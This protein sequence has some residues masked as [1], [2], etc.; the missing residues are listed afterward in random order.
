MLKIVHIITRFING[1]A[2]ENTLETCNHQAAAGHDVTL[3]Y[4]DEWTERMLARLNAG[5]TKICVSNLK[6]PVS[7]LNDILA[8]YQIAQHLKRIEPDVIHTHTSKA[9]FIG[10]LA[11]IASR[12]SIVVHGVHILPFTA[13]NKTQFLTYLAL[14]KIAAPLTD[15]FIDVSEGMRELCLKHKLGIPEN[16]DVIASGMDI[17]RFRRAEP[18]HDIRRDQNANSDATPLTLT[19][20]AVLERRKCHHELMTAIAPILLANPAT[21]LVFAG[22]GPERSK[23]EAH[24]RVLGIAQQMQFIGFRD[25]A[26]NVIAASDICLFYSEREGLPRSIVQYALGGKP[27]LAMHLP[28]IERIVRDGQNGYVTDNAA[29]F[30]SRLDHLLHSPDTRSDFGLHSEKMDLSAWSAKFMADEIE[31]VYLR[32]LSRR[33]KFASRHQKK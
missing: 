18:A 2:D 14:E 31:K 17:D 10:R 33:I 26:A 20:V 11:S 6:R 22:E 15:H 3:I 1:G 25:D 23:L 7:P 28:G 5:I 16:H 19:Y 27:I 30:A 8:L 12:K 32:A 9:G 4:G 29:D 13:E 21:S 24:A